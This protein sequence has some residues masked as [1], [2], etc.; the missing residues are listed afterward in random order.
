[1]YLDT[2][3]EVAK[4][5][6]SKLLIEDMCMAMKKIRKQLSRSEVKVKCHQLPNTSRVHHGTN[7]YQS[8]S[9]SD[10]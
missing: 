2:E 1:M 10:Q 3:N 7:S 9:I 6:H 8:T 4:L 5:R